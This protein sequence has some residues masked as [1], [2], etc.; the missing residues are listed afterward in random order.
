M[1]WKTKESA[2]SVFIMEMNKIGLIYLTTKNMLILKRNHQI[3]N[4]KNL[5]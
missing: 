1:K 2:Y 4:N 5:L 3:K